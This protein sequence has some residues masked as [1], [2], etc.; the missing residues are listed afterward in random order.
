M[1][2]QQTTVVPT[3]QYFLRQGSPRLKPPGQQPIYLLKEE[4]ERGGFDTVHKAVDV[5]TGD[6]YAVKKF[7]HD[8]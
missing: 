7:H 2:S 1:E 8:N 4:L 3:A 6:V 5:S